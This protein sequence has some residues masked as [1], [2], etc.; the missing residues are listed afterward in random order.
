MLRIITG[1]LAALGISIGVAN[2]Q[3]AETI[4]KFHN[5]VHAGNVKAVKAMLAVTPAL[6]T[7]EDKYKFQP[8]H[9]MDMYFEP[10]ILEAL[11][12]N[13]ANINARNDEGITILHVIT[14]PAAIPLLLKKGADIEA[15]D[16]RGWTPLIVQSG[17]RSNGP[18]VVTALLA[19]GANPNAKGNKGETA[20]TFARETNDTAFIAALRKGGA[21]E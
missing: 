8:I 18:G 5:A 15:R 19:S 11:L 21:K 7:S 2:A 3:D 10:E 4:R 12:A 20:L 1:L 13:G 17:N 6:A 9:L 16:V 14:D